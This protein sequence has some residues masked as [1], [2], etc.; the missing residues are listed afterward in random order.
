MCAALKQIDLNNRILRGRGKRKLKVYS[1]ETGKFQT[2]IRLL[3][4]NS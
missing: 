4:P 3:E 2:I 1:Y